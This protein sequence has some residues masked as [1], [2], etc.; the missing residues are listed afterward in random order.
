MASL[1][2]T[3]V[4]GTLT[5]SSTSTFSS[6]LKT[7]N[8][9]YF[10]GATGRI[11]LNTAD[12]ADTKVLYVGGG[13]DAGQGRGAY[14]GLYGNDHSSSPGTLEMLSGTSGAV[15]I[16][17]GGSERVTINNNGSIQYNGDTQQSWIQ[18]KDAGTLSGYIGAGIG[19]AASPNNLNTDFAIRAKT[20]LALCTNDSNA[21]KM[22]IL[23][24]S[25]LL[26]L[27]AHFM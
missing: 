19:L 20:K 23:A 2:S 18:F 5:V 16:Y 22:T 3:A 13:G 12:A 6:W 25:A 26:R 1:V 8:Y 14:I 21:A 9:L 15:K 7:T 11:L 27:I 10:D 24:D 4:T 17:S